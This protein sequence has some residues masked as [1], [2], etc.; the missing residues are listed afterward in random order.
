MELTFENVEICRTC[1]Q[2]ALV[3]VVNLGIQPLA[4]SLVGLPGSQEL[5]IPLVLLRCASCGLLQLSVNVNPSI[6]F[7]N[8]NWV[9]GTS[10]LT[11]EHCRM[12]ARRAIDSVGRT[13]LSVLEI[14]SNDGTLLKHLSDLGCKL[15]VGVDP[16]ENLVRSYRE[17][18]IGEISFFN[19]QTARNLGRKYTSF[20]L[21]IARNVFSHIP[22][23]RDAIRGVSNLME[24][25]SIFIMEFHW[26]YS[27]L[28]DNHFDSIYHEHTY[29]HSISSVCKILD[30]FGMVA[31]D[32][33]SSPISGGSIVLL[34]S[35]V[36]Q[37]P[38][39]RLAEF[40]KVEEAS[41]VNEASSWSTFATSAQ[42]TIIDLEKFLRKKFKS[43]VCGFG[44]S[45]RSST[46]LNALG[47]HSKKLLSIVD[48][49]ELKVGNFSPGTGIPIESL[50]SA[51]Q[52]NPKAFV[53]F[54]FNFE[55]EIMQQLRDSGWS[56]EV[57]FPLPHPAK[58]LRVNSSAG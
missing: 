49:N 23:F 45:A 10:A 17:P 28:K 53:V 32:A 20:D 31:F 18:L 2:S 30:E 54:A 40:Q 3:E 37:G 43:G 47:P 55:D 12:F 1:K 36:N 24:E 42:K 46:I 14:G 4:N 26:A 25:T 15:L 51:L 35:K 44:S 33:F 7:S 34:S 8:Y 19:S 41:G 22:D 48:N 13:K 50:T 27:I 38:S 5:K 6:M 21:I 56:G 39:P 52:R 58:T 57:Y 16:A 29:Y 9:T 11:V